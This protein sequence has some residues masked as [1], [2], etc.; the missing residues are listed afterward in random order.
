M[1]DARIGLER[2]AL[3]FLAR[4]NHHVCFVLN[5][6]V[7]EHGRGDTNIADAMA[8]SRWQHEVEVWQAH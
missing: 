5:S 3:C 8:H 2:M 6:S 7:P 1:E 4:Y